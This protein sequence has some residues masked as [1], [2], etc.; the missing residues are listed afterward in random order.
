MISA[1]AANSTASHAT[2]AS[3]I[4]SIDFAAAAVTLPGSTVVSAPSA[5]PALPAASSS[6]G[7][8]GWGSLV[9][10]RKGGRAPDPV[11]SLNGKLATEFYL[12]Y[13]IRGSLP[14]L[15]KSDKSRGQLLVD[16]FDACATPQE[17]LQLA[18]QPEDTGP[19]RIIVKHLQRL[20]VQKLVATYQEAGLNVPRD[21]LKGCSNM[22]VGSLESRIIGLRQRGVT[23]PI[24]GTVAWQRIRAAHPSSGQS[25]S[26]DGAVDARDVSEDN[27]PSDEE[28]QANVAGIARADVRVDA[29]DNRSRLTLPGSSNESSPSTYWPGM[30]SASVES[31]SKRQR[32]A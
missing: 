12:E 8:K 4:A 16:W 17:R 31:A 32:D 7:V 28:S 15:S 9:P 3:G 18:A 11:E 2:A 20:V 29:A 26:M 19:L 14:S 1:T 23:V 10:D 22:S 30:V 25:V 5:T 21:V 6:S 27:P 24:P 13:K